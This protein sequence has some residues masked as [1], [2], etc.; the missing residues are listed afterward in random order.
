MDKR[1]RNARSEMYLLRQQ[2]TIVLCYS[3]FSSHPVSSLPDTG[4]TSPVQ[5]RLQCCSTL[6]RVEHLLASVDA[7]HHVSWTSSEW[8]GGTVIDAMDSL[9]W[10]LS[11]HLLLHLFHL[12]HLQ[13][14]QDTLPTQSS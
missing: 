6:E 10:T 9:R 4:K 8:D 13:I 7:S 14:H 1:P 11:G 3:V 5:E 12:N 2:E